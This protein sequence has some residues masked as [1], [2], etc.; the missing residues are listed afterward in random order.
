MPTQK[1]EAEAAESV[2]GTKKRCECGAS[3]FQGPYQRGEIINGKFAHH[4]IVY[5]CRNCHREKKLDEIAD[6]AIAGR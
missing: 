4:E 6:D 1:T 2:K 3:V 5:Q